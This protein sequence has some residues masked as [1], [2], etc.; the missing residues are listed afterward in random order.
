[1]D[2]TASLHNVLYK[3]VYNSDKDPGN[4]QAS[5]RWRKHEPCMESPN[6]PRQVKSKFKGKFIISFDIKGIVPKVFA[7][8]GQTVYSSH[9][10]DVLLQLLENV[11]RLRPELWR[12]KNRLLYQDNA[13][14]HTSCFTREFFTKNDVTIV[15][16]HLTFR[17][18]PDWR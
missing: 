7:L 11:R 2:P 9:H 8:A 17:C 14:S 4:D 10:C 18:F 16:T 6:S 12:Q 13:P 5:I 1:M 15:P 3:S